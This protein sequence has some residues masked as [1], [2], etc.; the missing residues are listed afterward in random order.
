M[1]EFWDNLVKAL[2]QVEKASQTKDIKAC[3]LLLR[4]LPSLRRSASIESIANACKAFYGRDPAWGQSTSSSQLPF[5]SPEA[6]AFLNILFCMVLVKQNLVNDS[7]QI[8]LEQIEKHQ[9]HTAQP[10]VAK[11]FYYLALSCE[12]KQDFDEKPFL[13]WYR[14]ACLRHDNFIQATLINVILR[15]FLLKNK[16]QQ[17]QDFADRTG[18]PDNAPYAEIARNQYYLGRINA[19]RLNYAEALN[20]I[21]QAQRKAPENS[22]AGFKLAVEKLKVVVQLLMGEIPVRKTLVGYKGLGAYVDLVR[23]VRSGELERYNQVI[24]SYQNSFNEDMNLSLVARLRHIVIKAGLKKINIA[25]SVISL[26]DIAHKLGLPLADT[27][28]IVAKA[29]R[30][31]VIEAAV[32]HEHAVLK[33]KVLEDVYRTNEPQHAF[34]KRISFCMDLRND[35]VRAMQ[36]PQEKKV[37]EE[38]NEEVEIEL[39]EEDEDF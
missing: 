11:L 13:D 16:V 24:T 19:L 7:K 37:S 9:T 8:A 15:F 27:E 33:S 1:E 23:A 30:D 32:D 35:A 36:F 2:G 38:Y 21:I 5:S 10:F 29:I 25:Y 28:F 18:F 12:I 3:A 39:I 22:G 14:Q 31:G 34:Q 26:K 6:E 4:L 20:R 17:A